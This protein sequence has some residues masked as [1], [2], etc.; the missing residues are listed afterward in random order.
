MHSHHPILHAV[1]CSSFLT[2]HNWRLP[3][4]PSEHS[5]K[6]VEGNDDEDKIYS[7]II[8][9]PHHPQ[10]VSEDCLHLKIVERIERIDLLRAYGT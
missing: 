8:I 7:V 3:C 4:V 2:F 5:I 1:I 9:S 6:L 10:P